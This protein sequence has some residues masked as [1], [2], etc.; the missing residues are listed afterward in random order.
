MPNA[1]DRASDK[2]KRNL[3][4]PK[5]EIADEFS[6]AEYE[7]KKRVMLAVTRKIDD[8]IIPDKE[9]IEFLE[10]GCDG[11]C[12]PVSTSTAYRDLLL[13]KNITGNIK[14]ASKDWER[15]MVVE[16]AKAEIRKSTGKDS[17]AVASL[18]KVITE[19]RQLGQDDKENFFDLMVP[20]DYEITGDPEALG[21]MEGEQTEKIDYNQRRKEL[22]EL[23][24]PGDIEDIE[25]I[26]VKDDE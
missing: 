19:V 23:Y 13:I 21:E 11:T 2:I 20:P 17:R 26:Y 10:T 16:T 8:P 1:K 22:R 4:R 7:R 12:K 18:L 15:Y 9:I 25:V 14:L 6:E 5:K 24:K 3:F